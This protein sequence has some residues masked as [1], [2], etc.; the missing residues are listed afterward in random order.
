MTNFNYCFNL[1]QKMKPFFDKFYKSDYFQ[2]KYLKPLYKIDKKVFVK[3]IIRSEEKLLQ[4]SIHCDAILVLS[5]G[6]RLLFDDKVRTFQY[7]DCP[8][9]AIEVVSNAQK[10]TDGWGYKE[11]VNIAF[12]QVNE[13]NDALIG[14]PFCFKINSIFIENII[15]NSLF[16]TR[17]A[18]TDE[19]Y[20][21][22]IKLVPK[23]ELEKYWV[24]SKQQTLF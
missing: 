18:E 9:W 22:I 20:N 8:N 24:Y 21:T 15:R 11:G 13:T 5:N 1:S 23:E 3:E 19:L 6:N 10:Q 14:L 12:G 2:E 16:P 7:I 17:V 4:Q